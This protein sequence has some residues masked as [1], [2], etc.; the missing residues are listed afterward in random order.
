MEGGGDALGPSRHP[1][2]E[3]ALAPRNGACGGGTLVHSVAR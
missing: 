1:T 3:C 2:L